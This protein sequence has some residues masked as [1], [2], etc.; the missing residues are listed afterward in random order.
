MNSY[1]Q[2]SENYRY[3][4]QAVNRIA[5]DEAQ[6]PTKFWLVW[7]DDGY[8]PRYRHESEADAIREARRLSSL[9]PKKQFFILEAMAVVEQAPAPT[10]MTTLISPAVMAATGNHQS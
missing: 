6:G 2:C 5:A 3:G 1:D 10:R 7:N 9:T 4:N 8:P